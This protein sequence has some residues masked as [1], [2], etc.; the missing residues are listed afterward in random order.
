MGLLR[1]LF[2]FSVFLSHT[3]LQ[4]HL[5]LVGA[6]LAVQSFF[7]ISGFY[8]ALILENKYAGQRHSYKLFITNRFL[9]IYP[10]YWVVLA[11]IVFLAVIKYSFHLVSDENLIVLFFE[12]YKNATPFV[13]ISAFVTDLLRNVTLIINNDYLWRAPHDPAYLLISPAW[14]LQ[15]ELLFYL[16]APFLVR[17]RLIFLVFLIFLLTLVHNPLPFLINNNSFTVGFL[18]NLPYFLFGI[19]SFSLYRYIRTRAISNSMLH[20]IYIVFMLIVIFYTMLPFASIP[21]PYYTNGIY[22]TFLILALPYTFLLTKNNSFDRAIGV[23]SYPFYISHMLFIKLLDNVRLLST[24][25]I[26]FTI[27]A[28]IFALLGSFVL[29]KFIDKPI[30]VI[31]QRRVKMNT[32]QGKNKGKNKKNKPTE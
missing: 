31:R 29:E 15:I 17:L 30:D 8:M 9:R 24:H 21:L 19:L 11:I 13:I 14:T 3:P 5:P 6:G 16:L 1:L 18:I 7:V 28:F 12:Y 26:Y 32:L 2:A 4:F 22:L 20:T 10:V 23:L 27:I 25:P